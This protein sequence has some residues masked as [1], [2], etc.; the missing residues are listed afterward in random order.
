MKKKSDIARKGERIR[1]RQPE[2]D[3]EIE[4][5]RDGCGGPPAETTI[6]TLPEPAIREACQQADNGHAPAR[7][8][9]HGDVM[10][11]L[12]VQIAAISCDHNTGH[13]MHMT[14]AIVL[15]TEPLMSVGHIALVNGAHLVVLWTL[16]NTV[17]LPLEFVIKRELISFV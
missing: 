12:M 8:R 15:Y 16:Y 13:D 5:R 17:H 10:Q 4:T 3:I 14:V 2:D 11:S 9:Q 6:L 1:R 7:A